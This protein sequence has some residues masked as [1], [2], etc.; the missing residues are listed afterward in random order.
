[1][2]AELRPVVVSLTRLYNETSEALGG[3]RA[4]PAK[5]REM[6]DN[7]R[8]IGLLFAKLNNQDISLNA[9]SKLVQ[10]CQALDSADFASAL[11]IQVILTTSEWDECNFWL[12]ALKRMIKTRQNMRRQ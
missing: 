3:P 8:K 12:A 4:N 1:M 6:E 5:K 2:A 7:S 11:H 9:A 10:L